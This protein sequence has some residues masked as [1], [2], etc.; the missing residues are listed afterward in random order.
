MTTFAWREVFL[1]AQHAAVSS[2]LADSIAAG[3]SVL[4][5]EGVASEDEC[6]QLASEASLAAAKERTAKGLDGLVRKPATALL[7][8]SGVT[9][10]DS[11]L[12]RQVR[13]M[14][15]VAPCL[16]T[17]LFG[18]ALDASPST[19]FDNPHLIWSEGEPAVNVYSPGGRF[20]PHQDAQSLT[21]LLNVSPRDDYTGGGT[22]FWSLHDAGHKGTKAESKPP[23]F[24]IAPPAGTALVFGG[25]VTHAAQP[26]LSG[27][28]IVAVASFSPSA[29]R[30]IIRPPTDLQLFKAVIGGQAVDGSL[31]AHA[32][33][34][35]QPESSHTPQDCSLE[36]LRDALKTHE[37]DIAPTN[38][39]CVVTLA[40]LSQQ[41]HSID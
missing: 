35:R 37:C 15:D 24:L 21:C 6:Q 18:E 23:T 40:S 14:Q 4:I 22:A 13:R 5:L 8:R 27:E 12:L 26:L 9:L 17:S 30:G 11:L 29:F 19:V 32:L 34:S 16:T 38:A 41:R 33:P 28:R 1:N 3:H 31:A 7:D 2:T 20:T 36:D 39:R 10:F 25:Q